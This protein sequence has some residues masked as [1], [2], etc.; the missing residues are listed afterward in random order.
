M[1]ETIRTEINKNKQTYSRKDQQSPKF[2][3]KLGQ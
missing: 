1:K 3:E 2:F